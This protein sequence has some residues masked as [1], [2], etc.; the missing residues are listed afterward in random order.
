M[1]DLSK[2]NSKELP[3]R[4]IAVTI[5]GDP[6]TVKIHP[7][8]GA[9]RIAVAGLAEKI[10]EN[11]LTFQPTI[12]RLALIFG[13]DLS[14]ADAEKLIAADP[15]AAIEIGSAVWSFEAEYQSAKEQE[16]ATAEKNSD[17]AEVNTGD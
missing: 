13:A 3:A 6:Q 1:I 14:E 2:L 8:T 10:A 11:D 4:E 16:R 15:E 9:G 17:P 12:I 5:S 7:L